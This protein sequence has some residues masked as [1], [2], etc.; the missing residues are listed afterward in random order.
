MARVRNIVLI[1]EHPV[2]QAVLRYFLSSQGVA[3][4]SLS[5]RAGLDALAAMAPD[6]V[7]LDAAQGCSG[8]RKRLPKARIIAV[9]D[10]DALVAGADAVLRKP[11]DFQ[12][13][14]Q[15]LRPL[16]RDPAGDSTGA[17]RRVLI[18]DDDADVL[19]VTRKVLESAGCAVTCI[20][21]PGEVLRTPPGDLYDLVLLDVMMPGVD[22]LQICYLL[23]QHY[24]EDLRICM[25]TA[26][27]VPESIQRAAQYGA[28]GWLTKPIRR[29]ELL[30]LV[31]IEKRPQKR[32]QPAGAGPSAAPA[33]RRE[34]R[35]SSRRPHVLVVDDDRD[36]LEYCRSVLAGAGAVV[37]AIQDPT[38]LR[39]V[40]P[41]GGKYDLVLV[42]LFMPEMDGIEVLRRFSADVRN[43]ASKLYVITAADDET[44][45]ALARRSGAD[46]YLTKPL[47]Q[48]ALLDLLAA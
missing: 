1:N 31:G 18:I 43:C 32:P 26:S 24:G 15:D 14:N 9:C 13:L 12:R 44:L 22:G 30:A 10:D 20:A 40:L 41:Q 3:S 11:L 23:R 27:T 36:I 6:L 29:P 25:M 7:V 5:P 19:A 17:R 16:L 4:I 33:P 45:R 34:T 21:D 39:D 28:D 8:V 37:D 42:D 48:Q 38:T 2:D 46:G 35:R 47:K